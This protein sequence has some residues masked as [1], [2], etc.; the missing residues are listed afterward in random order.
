MF[1]YMLAALPE[2]TQ[3]ARIYYDPATL[4]HRS[5]FTKLKQLIDYL[6][7][8]S[9]ISCGIRHRYFCGKYITLK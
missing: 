1:L 6:A 3:R 2:L 8:N 4:A 7:A 5:E 9:K